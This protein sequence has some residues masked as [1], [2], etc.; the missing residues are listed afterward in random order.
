VGVGIGL[1]AAHSGLG[2]DEQ[3]EVGVHEGRIT[4]R[5]AASEVGQ[6]LDRVVRLVASEA[7]GL[8]GEEIAVESGATAAPTAT[9]G[10]YSSRLTIF[11]GNAVLD[12]CAKLVEA[13]H[14]IVGD[15]DV[16]P[17]HELE[18][19]AVVGAHG[20]EHPTYGFG[21]HVALV[22]VA[23][24]TAAV[25]VEQLAL[26]YDCGRALDPRAVVDQLRGGAVHGLGTTLLEELHYDENGQPVGASFMDYLLPTHADVPPDLRIE[27]L[28]GLAATNPLGVKGAGEAG[29]IGVGAAVANALA[30]A[31]GEAGGDVAHLPLSPRTVAGLVARYRSASAV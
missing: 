25:T 15:V 26:A 14:E 16:V 5:T 12:A 27:V 29:V 10:T 22:A 3:V 24:A 9:Q 11:V 20:D 23:P 8:P 28:P 17:W 31:L 30:D 7:L 21:G 19:L 4:V 18:G 6:G 13:A 1:F 2:R